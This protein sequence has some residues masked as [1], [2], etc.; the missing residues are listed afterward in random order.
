MSWWWMFKFLLKSLYRLQSL[1]VL[2]SSL[3]ISSFLFISRVSWLCLVSLLLEVLLPVFCLVFLLLCWIWSF[4]DYLDQG[5]F[6]LLQLWQIV[7]LVTVAQVDSHSLLE[8]GVPC[9]RRLS[10]FPLRNQLLFWWFFFY[11]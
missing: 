1:V 2:C 8:L 7:L 9:S 11:M 4:L 3:I 6:F 5:K 10:E